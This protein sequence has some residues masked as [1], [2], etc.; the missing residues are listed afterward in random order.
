MAPPPLPPLSVQEP[1]PKPAALQMWKQREQRDTGGPVYPMSPSSK[2]AKAMNNSETRS[3]SKKSKKKT[4]VPASQFVKPHSPGR[5]KSGASPMR[6]QSLGDPAPSALVSD[7]KKLLR[8]TVSCPVKKSVQFGDNNMIFH[9]ETIDELSTETVAAVWWSSSDY[10]VIQQEYEAVLFLIETGKEVPPEHSARG[11]SKRTEEGA[12]ELYE[13]Q[14]NA[15]NAVL[16]RQDVLR[17]QKKTD[18]ESIAEVYL[19]ESE[20]MQKEALEQAQRDAAEV[21]LYMTDGSQHQQVASYVKVKKALE[22]PRHKTKLPPTTLNDSFA[23]L[24]AL[25]KRS[26]DGGGILHFSDDEETSGTGDDDVSVVTF[27]RTSGDHVAKKVKF[28]SEVEYLKPR[29]V[30][31]PEKDIARCWYSKSDLE[32]IESEFEP[33]LKHMHEVAEKG[34]ADANKDDGVDEGKDSRRGLEKSTEAG[35]RKLEERRQFAT[36][37]VRALQWKNQS[38]EAI[39][40][41][42]NRITKE[43]RKEAAKFGKQDAKEAKKYRLKKKHAKPP[44]KR[45]SSEDS[46]ISIELPPGPARRSKRAGLQDSGISTVSSTS[47][48]STDFDTSG[49]CCEHTTV[50]QQTIPKS[51]KERGTEMNMVIIRRGTVPSKQP[52]VVPKTR[53]TG[54]LVQMFSKRPTS[55]PETDTCKAHQSPLQRKAAVCVPSTK[56]PFEN[57]RLSPPSSHSDDEGDNVLTTALPTISLN[58]SDEEH[59]SGENEDLSGR[60]LLDLENDSSET[61]DPALEL[62]IMEAPPEPQ[63]EERPT[64]PVLTRRRRLSGSHAPSLRDLENTRES[65]RDMEKMGVVSASPYKKMFDAGPKADKVSWRRK[66]AQRS[67]SETVKGSVK[68]SQPVERAVSETAKGREDSM[69]KIATMSQNSEPASENQNVIEKSEH[70]CKL[71]VPDSVKRREVI[72]ATIVST[73][74]IEEPTSDDLN[75]E[76]VQHVFSSSPSIEDGLPLTEQ[77]KPAT[78]EA[79]EAVLEKSREVTETVLEKTGEAPESILPSI[80]S[81]VTSAALAIASQIENDKVGPNAIENSTLEELTPLCE[82][83]GPS[84][85]PLDPTDTPESLTKNDSEKDNVRTPIVDEGLTSTDSNEGASYAISPELLSNVC[86]QAQDDLSDEVDPS[87]F[88]DQPTLGATI[89]LTTS[90][91]SKENNRRFSSVETD[92]EAT[93]PLGNNEEA[94]DKEALMLEENE[95]NPLAKKEEAIFTEMVRLEKNEVNLATSEEKKATLDALEDHS[96]EDSK[97]LSSVEADAEATEPFATKVEAEDKELVMLEENKVNLATSEEEFTIQDTSVESTEPVDTDQ[98]SRVDRELKMDAIKADPSPPVEGGGKEKIE[99]QN[100][101]GPVPDGEDIIKTEDAGE[102]EALVEHDEAFEVSNDSVTFYSNL[103]GRKAVVSVKEVLVS[104]DISSA[105]PIAITLA[106]TGPDPDASKPSSQQTSNRDMSVDEP[107][108]ELEQNSTSDVFLGVELEKTSGSMSLNAEAVERP[109]TESQETNKGGY[110]EEQESG[111]SEK[112]ANAPAKTSDTET[113]TLTTEQ[114]TTACTGD[115]NDT[116]TKGKEEET[117]DIIE[118]SIGASA[119]DQATHATLKEQVIQ[120]EAETSSSTITADDAAKRGW[121]LSGFRKLF[122]MVSKDAGP[123]SGSDAAA[124]VPPDLAETVK[125]EDGEE[126]GDKNVSVASAEL[127]DQSSEHH[128]LDSLTHESVVENDLKV[129][130]LSESFSHEPKIDVQSSI[131]DLSDDV[132][133]TKSKPNTTATEESTG[134][135]A[136]A[137]RAVSKDDADSDVVWFKARAKDVV[138]ITM[139]DGRIVYLME[140]EKCSKME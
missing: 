32:R 100:D 38:A 16:S 124:N 113:D 35:A 115:L 69:S 21:K 17:K 131:S 61:G 27:A 89:P 74:N 31:E 125:S 13:N 33:L 44:P 94:A 4:Y 122:K 127:K 40:A 81:E 134:P 45:T 139:D 114:P 140:A 70:Y 63:R 48:F 105:E 71:A 97:N 15:R 41:A 52:M 128:K 108:I 59:M 112:Q 119:C 126:E 11:L 37:A 25:A 137:D 110:R 5:E 136:V 118:C 116:A 109:C 91:A 43:A 47:N 87:A 20:K 99:C 92:A 46:R 101:N 135:S 88:Y 78:M 67:V 66:N 103:N 76:V 10:M 80:P 26:A 28:Q 117:K 82:G 104:C 98:S 60:S 123:K 34:D 55:T 9:V 120:Q 30:A 107:K 85:V 18:P 36:K 75:L 129:S 53:S 106:A 2:K 39:A 57:E 111:G 79:K 64:R 1:D 133:E 23:K 96:K 77:P 29:K 12:W 22:K 130:P 49:D 24:G 62:E 86:E 56:A 50:R 132:F 65:I 8:K 72:V 84:K 58:G 7:N 19:K 102:V 73:S 14:R 54:E 83:A 90:D 42:Y 93:E 51:P 95:V 138:T 6:T 68:L 3:K 121:K